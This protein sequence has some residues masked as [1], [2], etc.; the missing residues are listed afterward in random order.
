MTKEMKGSFT[1]PSGQSVTNALAELIMWPGCEGCLAATS[2]SGCDLG[3]KTVMVR[4]EQGQKVA[5]PLQNC[6]RPELYDDYLLE[7]LKRI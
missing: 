4:N 2:D 5:R 3:A 1:A 7:H 6:P